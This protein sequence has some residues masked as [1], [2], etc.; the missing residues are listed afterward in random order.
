MMFFR[1]FVMLNMI[2]S[3]KIGIRTLKYPVFISKLWLF[4]DEYFIGLLV[5]TEFRNVSFNSQQTKEASK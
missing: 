5:D 4:L 1:R 3:M 2:I